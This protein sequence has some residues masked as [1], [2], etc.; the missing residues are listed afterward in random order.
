MDYLVTEAEFDCGDAAKNA[1]GALTKIKRDLADF[2]VAVLLYFASPKYEPHALAAGMKDAFPGALTFGCSSSGE[3]S[4]GVMRRGSVAAMAFSPAVFETAVAIGAGSIDDDPEAANKMLAEMEKRLGTSVRDLDFRKYFGFALIDG[5]SLSMEAI[6]ERVGELTDVI[7]TGGCAG[8]D[9]QFEKTMV[10]CDGVAHDNGAVLALLKPRGRFDFLK[11]QS[12]VP[13]ETVLTATA[14]DSVHNVIYEFD[15][16]PAAQAYADA[17]GVPVSGMSAENF[18][19]FP[20]A[21]MAGGEPFVRNVATVVPKNGVRL[22]TRPFEGMRYTVTRVVDL[23]D[24]TAKALEEKRRELGGISAV[25]NVNCLFRDLQVRANHQCE[26]FGALFKDFPCIGFSSYGEI[27]IGV[28][29][30]TAT[31]VVFG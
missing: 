4:N 30:Q 19:A 26:R 21:M 9:G 23:M 10:F 28:A 25:I 22:H 29:N 31:M 13:T 5:V 6:M 8:D 3:L 27:Y 20:L 17:M 7:F 11:T 24:D 15:G 18:A 2:P 16:K 1:A 14:V 12:L